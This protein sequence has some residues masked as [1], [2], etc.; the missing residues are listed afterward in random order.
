MNWIDVLVV[1]A[2]AG[3]A[4]VAYKQGLISMFFTMVGFAVGLV[5]AGRFHTFFG[6]S[7]AGQVL[8]FTVVLVGTIALANFAGAKAKKL[9]D[10]T[11]LGWT[12]RAGAGA[13]GVIV[14][15]LL[16]AAILAVVAKATTFGVSDV[17]MDESEVSQAVA[18]SQAWASESISESFLA[19]LLLEKFPLLRWLLPNEFGFLEHFFG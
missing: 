10:V 16:C 1:L 13:L 19:E 17:P 4:F 6:D 15:L 3:L 7:D 8:A 9:Y 2:T 11:R 12:D 18:A 14:G 5:L